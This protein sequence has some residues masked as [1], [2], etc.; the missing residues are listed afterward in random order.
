MSLDILNVP[1]A[2]LKTETIRKGL[3]VF[4]IEQATGYSVI[5]GSVTYLLKSLARNGDLT[6]F[7]ATLKLY[8][9][10]I[11]CEAE[12]QGYCSPLEA[13]GKPLIATV[14]A[15][16]LKANKIGPNL[17]D[18]TTWYEQSVYVEAEEATTTD[19]DRKIW[20]VTHTNI[21]D[22]YHG[23]L[24]GEDGLS[25]N[26]DRTY[27]VTVKIDATEKT[28]RDPH[29]GTG[30]DFTVDY[31]AG[32]IHFSESVGVNA[33]VTVT[34]HYE[35]GSRWTLR[36]SQGEILKL[37]RAE[38]QFSED[39]EITDTL[40]YDLYGLVDSFAPTYVY[41]RATGTLTFVN[42]SETVTG[43]GTTFTTELAAGQYICLESDLG[44][45]GPGAYAQIETV[46]SNT[47]LTLV[48]LYGG[49]SD[50]GTAAYSDYQSG[51]IPS[52]TLIQLVTPDK[53]KT[54]C[55]FINDANGMYPE[56]PPLGGTG[57]RGCPKKVYSFPWDFQTTT[58]LRSSSGMELRVYLEHDTPY[59]G[60]YVTGTFYCLRVNE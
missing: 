54:M 6:D 9:K 21:I 30:G 12:A 27:R 53:Y 51:V 46:D 1:Y 7:E 20:K 44:S 56:M 39:V 60:T 59:T 16:G 37:K 31:D 15:E 3:K 22:T 45:S 4:Y 48:S 18:R 55:D 41:K 52:G 42:N 49:S 5:A 35:N 50:S 40:V 23:K 14:P 57:W 34:Y 19:V 13:E 43:S 8:A 36:P 2:T 33:T 25:D 28:E 26:D 38:C 32:E 29:F 10:E 11:S 24:T 58:D 17:C 47:Q